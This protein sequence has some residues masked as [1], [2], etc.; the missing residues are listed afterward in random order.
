M[1]K[2][3]KKNIKLYFKFILYCVTNLQKKL[4][5]LDS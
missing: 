2:K 3:K 5:K 1:N 4:K